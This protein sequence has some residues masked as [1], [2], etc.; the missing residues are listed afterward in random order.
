MIKI[1]S[2]ASGYFLKKITTN[3]K[4]GEC[5][6]QHLSLRVLVNNTRYRK[7]SLDMWDSYYE[8]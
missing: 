5:L 7:E 6:T 8:N 1:V 4:E 3:L 2:K